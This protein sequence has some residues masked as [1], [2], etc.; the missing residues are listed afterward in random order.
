MSATGSTL[1]EFSEVTLSKKPQSEDAALPQEPAPSEE[2]A[3]KPQPE[4]VAS[5]EVVAPQN[6]E[7]AQRE[8]L[9]K[10]ALAALVQSVPQPGKNLANRLDKERRC[11]E[12]RFKD[13]GNKFKVL[14]DSMDGLDGN[15]DGLAVQHYA[16]EHKRYARV[17]IRLNKAKPPNS[18][19]KLLGKRVGM[20]LLPAATCDSKKSEV[21]SQANG[22]SSN[23]REAKRRR[24]DRL[25]NMQGVEVYAV[26]EGRDDDPELQALLEGFDTDNR[27]GYFK[28]RE[29]KRKTLTKAA[30]GRDLTVKNLKD[31]LVEI[32]ALA[33]ARGRE[34]DQY[35]KWVERCQSRGKKLSERLQSFTSLFDSID[36]APSLENVKY[37]MQHAA[38]VCAEINSFNEVESP[39][40]KA[41]EGDTDSDDTF[42]VYNEAL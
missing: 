2:P 8:E 22:R 7:A 31:K 3:Q 28:Q 30:D 27:L 14:Y 19:L 32:D 4:N 9:R 41:A 36:S 17:I 39:K 37:E 21:R 12:I 18:V 16:F 24:L 5:Q 34:R 38:A 40:S 11:C 23:E 33:E 26:P 35:G 1:R 6:D 42:F 25:R 10:A 13:P 29:D 15:V 20:E